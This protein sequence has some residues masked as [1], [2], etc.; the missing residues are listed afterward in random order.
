MEVRDSIAHPGLPSP[1]GAEQVLI[2]GR[3]VIPR[4]KTLKNLACG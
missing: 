3:E 2:Q 1:R 4:E